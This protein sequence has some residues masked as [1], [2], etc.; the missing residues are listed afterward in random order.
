MTTHELRDVESGFRSFGSL[1]L[2]TFLNSRL[3][4]SIRG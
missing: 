2:P 4:V 3:F 1:A